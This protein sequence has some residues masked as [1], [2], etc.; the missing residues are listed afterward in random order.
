MSN[1]SGDDWL[2]EC[3]CI[4]ILQENCFTSCWGRRGKRRSDWNMYFASPN[5][6]F[7]TQLRQIVWRLSYRYLYFVKR[8]ASLEIPDKDSSKVEWDF[9]YTSLSREFNEN[10]RL[11]WEKKP[12]KGN[13]ARSEPT[14][15]R[16]WNKKCYT[17]K[18]GIAASQTTQ[19]FVLWCLSDN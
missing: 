3:N 4:E 7:I 11:F 10:Q 5:I 15:K 16:L 6:S 19:I 14:N 12:T 18:H 17:Y 13:E 9:F 1:L 8:W 2:S